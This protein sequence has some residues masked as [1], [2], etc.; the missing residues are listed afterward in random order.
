MMPEM[1]GFQ[2]LDEIRGMDAWLSIPVIV[3]TAKD[4]T[5]AERAKLK[6]QTRRVVQKGA[7]RK[8]DLLDELRRATS[9]AASP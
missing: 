6:E 3:V 1:D 2:F 7:Y 9:G 8:T 5:V 4:L